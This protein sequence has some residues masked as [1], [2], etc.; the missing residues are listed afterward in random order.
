MK[1]LRTSLISMVVTCAS[2]TFG[3]IAFGQTS[4]GSVHGTISDPD[5]AVIP[6]ASI[7]LRSGNGKNLDSMSKGDG[8]F[9]FINLGSGQYAVT[10]SMKGFAPHKEQ[11]TISAGHDSTLDVHLKIQ[12]ESE[13]ITVAEQPSGVSVDQ[14]NSASSK[15]IKGSDLD[16]LDDDPD[17]LASQLAA[18]AGPGDGPDGGVMYIDGFTGGQIP[19]KSSIREIRINQAP[20]SAQY[21][22]FGAGRIEIFTKPGSERFHGSFQVNGNDS[23]MNTGNPLL[24]AFLTPGQIPQSQPPYY[25][26]LTLGSFTGPLSRHS[27][28]SFAE[29]NR[30]IRDN[31]LVSATV[32]ASLFGCPGGQ[33]SCNFSASNPEPQTRWDITPRIDAQLGKNNT[34]MVRA[35]Y[36][37]N[38]VVNSG[39]G[40][41]NLPSTGV[42]VSSE[43]QTLQVSDTQI[44]SQR[45][46]NESR[47]EYQRDTLDQ[48]PL[49]IAPAITVSGSFTGGGASSGISSDHQVHLEG[50]D[51]LA[52][53]LSKHFLRLG[54][55]IR[56]TRD[57]NST[58]AGSNGIFTYNCIVSSA[59]SPCSADAGG[60]VSSYETGQASQFSITTQNKPISATLVDL[61]LYAEDEWK[62]TQRLDVSYGIRFETQN[63]IRDHHDFAP[64]LAVAYGLGKASSPKTVLRVGAGLFYQRFTLPN[65][66]TTIRQNGV[67]QA[68]LLITDPSI[69]CNPNNIAACSGGNS[70]NTTYLASQSLRTPYS[71]MFA[72]G[73]DQQIIRGLKLSLNFRQTRG[74]HQ[75][76]SENLNAPRGGVYPIPPLGSNAPAVNYRFESGAMFNQSRLDLNLDAKLG[77]Y[78]SLYGY[79]LLNFARSDT[80]GPSTFPT[81]PGN[82]RADYG[83]GLFAI[84]QRSYLGGSASLPFG[85]TWSFTLVG[86]SGSPYNV[87]LGTDLNKD[88]IYNERP[89]FLPGKTQ[90]DCRN[91][92]SFAR[93][94]PGSQYVSIPINYCTG[95]GSFVAYTRLVKN[96]GIGAPRG[97]NKASG[98]GSDSGRRYNLS[99]G[100]Q[101]QNLFNN[102]D[103]STP[104]GVLTSPQFGRSTQLAGDPF[105]ANDSLRR[106]YLQ[107]A[108]SF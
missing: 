76:Y 79:T 94:V 95:P 92:A 58:N 78:L 30:I 34:L 62:P 99:I 60:I 66:M 96:F 13:Q 56:S 42:T 10:I 14:D 49:S 35:A 36:D 9:R 44:I 12:G 102:A 26:L 3:V 1:T 38:K 55:R 106:I 97:S 68:Q 100:I 8:S 15:T 40:N 93:P 25:T 45:I 20:F 47:V 51:Y 41:L 21:D 83:R 64:R 6:G 46:I 98:R 17:D 107:S 91:A 29:S 63:H 80:A 24:N 52:I 101:F 82:I 65:I 31:T 4:V 39:V 33:I 88:S 104:Q 108:F 16:A 19:P 23:S 50:Q 70:G 37:S 86:W 74:L 105:T 43:E 67:N 89:S 32:P 18:L 57:A 103:V 81:V 77:K 53:A 27:S 28:F 85:L 7:S 69:L 72:A 54:G 11:I 2:L 90:A 75:F 71:M 22:H 5:N 84:R 87:T 61:G 73:V 59:A 48:S